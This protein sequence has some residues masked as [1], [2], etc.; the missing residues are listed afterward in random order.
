MVK[1]ITLGVTFFLPQTF[2]DFLATGSPIFV[3]K[4]FPAFPVVT[5]KCKLQLL[6]HLKRNWYRKQLNFLS[7]Q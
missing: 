4:T 2:L 7:Y 1:E 3:N 5:P 6:A